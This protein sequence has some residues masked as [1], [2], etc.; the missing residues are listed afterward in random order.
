MQSQ[1]TESLQR[2]P[3]LQ[4]PSQASH[5]TSQ[6]FSQSPCQQQLSPPPNLR[7]W[8]SA[9]QF[10]LKCGSVPDGRTTDGNQGVQLADPVA[11]A[12]AGVNVMADVVAPPSRGT[13]ESNRRETLVVDKP[14]LG[15]AMKKVEETISAP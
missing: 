9:D 1:P 15:G 13:P 6:Q 11:P 14:I 4:Q 2:Q 12:L 5:P 7:L 10:R 3:L 8:S